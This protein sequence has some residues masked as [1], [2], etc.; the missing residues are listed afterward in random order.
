M[1]TADAT[2]PSHSLRPRSATVDWADRL[3][4]C[5][6]GLG[7]FG[8][9]IALILQAD[10]GAAPWDVFHQG[11]SELTGISIGNVII[12]VGV[13]LLLAWIPLHQ[14]PGVGTLLNALEIG[15]MVDLVLPLLPDTDGCCPARVP[16]RS[17]C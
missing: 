2:A 1:P 17:D 10:L 7:L 14:R 15:L 6:G 3:A 13:V 4:R 5:I 12:I 8:L 9:G 11:L 16:R